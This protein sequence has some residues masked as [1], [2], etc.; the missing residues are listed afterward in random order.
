MYFLQQ[1]VA[2][3]NLIEPYKA[4][5]SPTAL[6]RIVDTPLLIGYFETGFGLGEH[7][8]G[9][10]AALEAAGMPFAAYPYNGFTGRPCD[11]APWASCYDVDN[12]H[13]INIFCMAPDQTA[14]ARRIIER[15][16]T[17]NSY[18]ILIAPWELPHAPEV[19]A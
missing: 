14:N 11:E 4:R 12:V 5:N 17:E 16:H 3:R 18:N 2:H 1:R 15:R 13:T 9:L 19:L 7:V 6:T 10:A 8:K